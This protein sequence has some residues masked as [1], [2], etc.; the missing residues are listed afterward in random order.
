M[1]VIDTDGGFDDLVALYLALNLKLEVGAV[2]TCF[3]NTSAIT[4]AENLRD[5]LEYSGYEIPVYR[6]AE[7]PIEGIHEEDKNF[8]GERGLFGATL[9]RGKNKIEGFAGEY[10]ASISEPFEIISLAPMTNLC[11]AI[12]NKNLKKIRVSSGYF[13]LNEVKEKRMAWNAKL[14]PSAYKKVFSS[15]VPIEVVGLDA[16]GNFSKNISLKN[17]KKIRPFLETALSFVRKKGLRDFTAISDAAVFA[18]VIEKVSGE[19]IFSDNLDYTF[20][21][22]QKK[23]SGKIQVATAIDF[24]AFLSSLDIGS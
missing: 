15:G 22:L 20:S 10:Y 12:K 1:I 4:A 11:E 19:V 13:N 24:P 3:G 8:A 2:M 7:N 5:F 21:H 9:R 17:N 14:D 23:E 6:G 16:T 18:P